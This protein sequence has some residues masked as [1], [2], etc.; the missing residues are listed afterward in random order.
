MPTPTEDEDYDDGG[1]L[2]LQPINYNASRDELIAALKSSQ[3]SLMKVLGENRELQKPNSELMAVSTKKRRK[4]VEK[5]LLGY[6]PHITALAKKFLFT[7]ALFIDS[8]IFRLNL[9]QPSERPEDQFVSDEAYRNSVTIALYQDIPEKFHSL[10]DAET[11]GSFAKDF[12]HEHSDGRST[13]ISIIRK[14]LPVIL[15]GFNIDSDLLTTA[16]ADRSNNEALK[17]FLCFPNERKATLYAPVL[18]PGPTRNMN[19]LFTGPVVM[20]VHRLMYFGPGSLVPGKK[21]APNSNGIRMGLKQ[22]TESS[23]SAAGI[24]TRFVLS[25]DKEWGTSKTDWEAEYRAYHKLLACN[26]HLPHVKRIFKKIH[27]FVFDGIDTSNEATTS[28]ADSDRETEDAIADAMRQFELGTDPA[29]VLEDDADARG[30]VT[31]VAEPVT[32][33]RQ[34]HFLDAELPPEPPAEAQN[35]VP[36]ADVPTGR[37]T[38]GRNAGAIAGSGEEPST[39]TVATRRKRRT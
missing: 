22:V 31:P 1:D 36:D 25:P 18:F 14:T 15:K 20:K 24:L 29:S 10:L 26:R 39:T 23:I 6:Q 12:I 11:Y 33:V 7:R 32:A 8:A 38:R 28:D 21:P 2:H 37:R 3:L 9:P 35:A 34:V 5:D 27:S 13:L 30:V 17:H 19:E 16:G 4:G